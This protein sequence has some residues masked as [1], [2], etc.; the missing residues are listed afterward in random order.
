[1]FHLSLDAC[2]KCVHLDVSKVD[3][4]LYMVQYDSPATAAFCSCLGT[5]H[6]CGKQRDRAL[7]GCGR[8]KRRGKHGEWRGRSLHLFEIFQGVNAE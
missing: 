8:G 5:V 7:R 1:V 3:E 4:V 6:A 2:C